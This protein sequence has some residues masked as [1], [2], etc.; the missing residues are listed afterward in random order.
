MGCILVKNHLVSTVKINTYKAPCINLKC[1]EKIKT[2]DSNLSN[3]VSL[4]FL[5]VGG[6]G[7]V[8]EAFHV[9]SKT[10]RALKIISKINFKHK[11]HNFCQVQRESLILSKLSHKNIIGYFETLEDDLKFYII[12][13]LCL[14]GSLAE[15]LRK[16]K[17]FSEAFTI[18]IMKQVL[19]AVEYLHSQKIIHRDIKLENILLKDSSSNSIKLIDFGC[20]EYIKPGESLS[21][22]MGSLFYLAPEVIKGNSTEK[23]DVWSC[24]ILAL[25][26]LTGTLPYL[27]KNLTEIKEEIRCLS[28]NDVNQRILNISFEAQNFIRQMLEVDQSKRVTAG[29]ARK[30]AWLNNTC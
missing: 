28:N 12:T 6:Y 3:Y 5:G 26:M 30:H 15:K 11:E 19:D 20:S 23:T 24:G 22:C 13:E 16:S 1:L 29:N 9:P 27:G 10:Y 18:E 2:S 25:I 4:S 14:G 8:L 7:E 21:S 17:K